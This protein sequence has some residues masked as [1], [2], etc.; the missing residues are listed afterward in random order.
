MQKLYTPC[1]CCDRNQAVWVVFGSVGVC[2]SCRLGVVY[3][4]RDS[5]G[6]G[7]NPFLDEFMGVD[8]KVYVHRLPDS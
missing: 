3:W 2:D 1:E 8:R 7:A 6:F 4:F 5:L